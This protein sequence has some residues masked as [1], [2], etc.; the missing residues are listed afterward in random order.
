MSEDSMNDINDMVNFV[1]QSN[2]T[3]D[4]DSDDD[5]PDFTGWSVPQVSIP[6]NTTIQVITED[7]Q[8]DDDIPDYS[9]WNVNSAKPIT[10]LTQTTP[11]IP[12][13]QPQDEEIDY[14]AKKLP[15]MQ[16]EKKKFTFDVSSLL[17]DVDEEDD[18]DQINN[19]SYEEWKKKQESGHEPAAPNKTTFKSPLQMFDTLKQMSKENDLRRPMHPQMSKQEHERFVSRNNYLH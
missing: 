12:A 5:V 4:H 14:V 6:K 15:N 16:K 9:S 3:N 10:L 19:M 18:D 17:Y 2:T 8:N 13:P 1:E 7:Y 11:I